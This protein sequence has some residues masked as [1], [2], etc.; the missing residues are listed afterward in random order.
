[1]EAID[2]DH[3]DDGGDNHNKNQNKFAARLIMPNVPLYDA[4]AAGT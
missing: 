3:Y 4:L 1:M 2:I